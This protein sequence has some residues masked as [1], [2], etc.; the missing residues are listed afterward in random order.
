MHRWS[1]FRSFR[2]IQFDQENLERSTIAF[3]NEITI[4][5]HR[6]GGSHVD[7]VWTELKHREASQFHILT[8]GDPEGGTVVLCRSYD[9]MSQFVLDWMQEHSKV[10][11]YAISLRQNMNSIYLLMNSMAKI[12]FTL[13]T[14]DIFDNNLNE[15]KF[16]IVHDESTDVLQRIYNETGFKKELFNRYLTYLQV[17][18]GVDTILSFDFTK[19]EII[20]KDEQALINSIL[21]YKILK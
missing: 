12:S 5:S 17:S 21:D 2:P 10:V 1:L 20:T 11:I 19:N 18:K 13:K 3:R 8:V 6:A 9:S 16:D 14:K 7:V 15:I 4:S